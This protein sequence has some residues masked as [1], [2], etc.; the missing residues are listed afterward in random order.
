[1]QFQYCINVPLSQCRFGRS[2]EGE[3]VWGMRGCCQYINVICICIALFLYLYCI[4]VGPIWPTALFTLCFTSDSSTINWKE[5][6]GASS[7]FVI[8]PTPVICRHQFQ[9]FWNLLLLR[10]LSH[11]YL[12]NLPHFLPD[13]VYTPYLNPFYYSI[14]LQQYESKNTCVLLHF[15]QNIEAAVHQKRVDLHTVVRSQLRN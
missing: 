15:F 9:Y 3:C 13:E 1:M 10:Y 12:F 7:N 11:I 8:Y 2:L 6:G 4:V 5:T 14:N